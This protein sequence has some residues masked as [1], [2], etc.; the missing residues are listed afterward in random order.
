MVGRYPTLIKELNAESPQFRRLNDFKSRRQ[1]SFSVAEE[2]RAHWVMADHGRNM[3][4][5]G[6][7]MAT[8]GRR[9]AL[10]AARWHAL[11]ETPR[12][13]VQSLAL[14]HSLSSSRSHVR[15]GTAMAELAASVSPLPPGSFM[16]IRVRHQLHRPP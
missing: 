5:H 9:Q 6:H 10:N 14:T 15:R 2:R 1:V 3:L 11:T 12:Y 7:R 16:S 13:P 8:A 4:S